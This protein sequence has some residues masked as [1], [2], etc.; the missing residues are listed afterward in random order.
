MPRQRRHGDLQSGVP[1]PPLCRPNQA[2][3]PLFDG[4]ASA[5][6]GGRVDRAPVDQSVGGNQDRH[7]TRTLGGWVRRSPRLASVQRPVSAEV[8]PPPHKEAVWTSRSS[9]AVAGHLHQS[10]HGRGR[11]S[12]CP[13]TGGCRLV[14]EHAAPASLLRADLDL[15]RAIGNRQ[16]HPAPFSR[17]LATTPGSRP[18]GCW[19]GT[20]LLG[21][22]PFRRARTPN[23]T[24]TLRSAPASNS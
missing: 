1:L 23:P 8:V 7:Q 5:L 16:A 24:A 15:H 4:V 14:G 11:S 18:V 9:G 6:G 20:E 2:S 10:L 12:R 17:G 21:R 22:V 19:L 3:D 13:R